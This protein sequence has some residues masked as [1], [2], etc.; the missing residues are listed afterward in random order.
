MAQAFTAAS[1]PYYPPNA[2]IKGYVPN[3]SPL[4]ELLVRSGLILGVTVISA[5]W[6][7]TRFNPR[8]SLADKCVYGWFLLCEFQ[9]STSAFELAGG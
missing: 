5:L 2:Q 1:H 9:D 6:L 7:A 4:G 3:T 8:L